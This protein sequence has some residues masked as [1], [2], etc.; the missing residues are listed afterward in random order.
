MLKFK[1]VAQSKKSK[2]L[3]RPLKK[4]VIVTILICLAILS[5]CST[6]TT[7]NRIREDCLRKA[8]TWGDVLDC[9]VILDNLYNG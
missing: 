8:I 9:S 3:S 4:I 6:K 2:Q 1:P 5:G 7:N